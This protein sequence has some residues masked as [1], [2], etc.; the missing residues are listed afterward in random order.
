ME[1]ILHEMMTTL[2][3]LAHEQVPLARSLDLLESTAE[4]YNEL[5]VLNV[6]RESL[7]EVTVE[8]LVN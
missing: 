3:T 6:I 4:N 2:E 5:I 8:S 7:G 1:D